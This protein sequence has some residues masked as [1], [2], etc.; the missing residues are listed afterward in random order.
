MKEAKQFPLVASCFLF[1]IYLL[2]K[3]LS[4]YIF[5]ALVNVYFS[6]AIVMSISSILLELLPFGQSLRK[7]FL[8]IKIPKIIQD[9]L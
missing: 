8:S 2:Y 5:M 1:G 6:T 9:L 4:K 7:N 3:Y